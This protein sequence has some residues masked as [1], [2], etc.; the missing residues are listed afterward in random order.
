MVQVALASS[1]LAPCIDTLRKK[2]KA[3][4]FS[5]A[6]THA[7]FIVPESSSGQRGWAGARKQ[8]VTRGP[9]LE[10][11]PAR[12]CATPISCVFLHNVCLRV[13]TLSV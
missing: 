10:A 2:V 5:S 13:A 4:S 11:I 6:G 8:P 9:I 1:H 7:R 3:V 12:H